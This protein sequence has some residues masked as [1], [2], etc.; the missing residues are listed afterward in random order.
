MS[1]PEPVQA[2]LVICRLRQ[3]VSPAGGDVPLRGAALDRMDVLEGDLW[4]AARFGE[5]VAIGQGHE[6]RPRLALDE[7]AEI[8]DAHGMVA[9]PGLVDCHTHACFVGDR[10]AE[11]EQRARGATYEELAAAGGGILATVR[12]TRAAG[13]DELTDAT[14]RHLGWMLAQGT[15]TAEV[16]SGYGLDAESEDRMLRAIRSASIGNQRVVPTLLALHAVPPEEDVETWVERAIVEVLPEAVEWGLADAVDV[17]VERGAYDVDQAR[18]WLE[19]AAEHDLAL[20][21]HGD[22]FT[23]MGAVDL[24]VEMSARSVDHLEATGP[25]GVETLAASDVTSVLLPAAALTL[26]RPMP[27]ARAL[28][29]GGAAIALA[30]DFNPGSSFCES[31]PLVMNLACTQMGLS[32][33]EALAACTVNGAHVLGQDERLGRLRVGAPADVVVLDAPDWRHL[34]YHM[35]GARIRHVIADGHWALGGPPQ[36]V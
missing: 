13:H 36:A 21:L 8:V 7:G 33:A 28:V 15:T 34:A 22:Q 9:V 14:S 18:R 16:K 4:L 2:D 31:L 17:F 11:F 3:L 6:I 27:P 23:E 1:A 25:E 26:R 20:R 24:A 35:G 12:A 19:A 30:T 29:D 5:I 32:P 10:A